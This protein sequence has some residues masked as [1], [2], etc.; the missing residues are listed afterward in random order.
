M[1]KSVVTFFCVLVPVIVS[2]VAVLSML[3]M[4][5]RRIGRLLCGGGSV[6]SSLLQ[7]WNER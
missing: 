3:V 5:Q 7:E 1:V 2:V 6:F 4:V